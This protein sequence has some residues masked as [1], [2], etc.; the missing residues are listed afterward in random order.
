MP[1][2]LAKKR[3]VDWNCTDPFSSH[4]IINKPIQTAYIQ[5]NSDWNATTG[6]TEIL[7]K[8]A[9][10]DVTGPTGPAGPVGLAGPAGVIGATG[11][12][13]IQ[14]LQGNPGP[15]GQTGPQGVLG[16]PGVVNLPALVWTSLPINNSNTSIYAAGYGVPQYAMSSQG[17]VFLRGSIT[18]TGSGG[19]AENC[20]L[21]AGY[22]PSTSK[23]VIATG[24]VAYSSVLFVVIIGTDGGIT[25]QYPDYGTVIQLDAIEFPIN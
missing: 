20:Q 6:I 10:T 8:P 24:V 14:G 12:A 15:I 16:P 1:A 17:I 23:Y 21:P 25:L 22:R 4:Y 5:I 2:N 13:G 11:L 9:N 7:N 18:S 3:F 19:I